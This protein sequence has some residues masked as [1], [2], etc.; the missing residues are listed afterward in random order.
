MSLRAAAVSRV[1]IP[2]VPAVGLSAATGGALAL[3]TAGL[4]TSATGTGLTCLFAAATGV[5]CPFC[6]LTHGVAALGAG[7][8]GAAVAANPLA[9]VAVALALAVP[10]TLL[11][12]RR[13]AVAPMAFWALTLVVGAAWLVRVLA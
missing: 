11:V 10:V 2:V 5:P 6:G 7:D 13:L 1:E 12:R 8:L 3:G 4:V 9:P